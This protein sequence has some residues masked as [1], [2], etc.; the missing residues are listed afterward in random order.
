MTFYKI[1]PLPTW[2]QSPLKPTLF[3]CHIALIANYHGLYLIPVCFFFL[4]YNLYK[5][6][7]F[8]FFILNPTSH[9]RQQ[10]WYSQHSK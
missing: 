5:G 1:A 9:T 7:E 6:K 10:W 8:V 4:R 2:F 3:F